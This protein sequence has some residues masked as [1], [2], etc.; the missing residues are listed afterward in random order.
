MSST[1]SVPIYDGRTYYVDVFFSH[2]WI[3]HITT[4]TLSAV[5]VVEVVFASHTQNSEAKI[6]NIF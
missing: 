3:T 6:P 5:C 4:T 1:F 2:L